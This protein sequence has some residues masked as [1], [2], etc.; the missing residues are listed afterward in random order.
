KLDRARALLV[1]VEQSRKD[2]F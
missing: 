2:V 1:E